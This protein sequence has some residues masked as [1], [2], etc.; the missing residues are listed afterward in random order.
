MR[1]TFQPSAIEDLEWYRRYYE[2][3]FPKGARR[4][5]E[6]FDQV[7]GTLT[8]NP[9]AGRPSQRDP[10]AREWPVYRTPFLLIYRVTPARIEVLR[11]W[12]N[13]RDPKALALR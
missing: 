4:V 9:E 12:D 1:V 2:T 8:A 11:V 7:I 5:A 3:V 10:T 13:R 6:H